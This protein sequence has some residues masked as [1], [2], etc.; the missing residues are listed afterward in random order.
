MSRLRRP[1]NGRGALHGV[2]AKVAVLVL[3]GVAVLTVA[4]GV[5]A[6]QNPLAE[7]V[8]DILKGPSAAHWFG[9][10]YLGRDL[11]SRIIA[12]TRLSV[13]TALEAVAVAVVLG[14]TPALLCLAFGK[15]FD[16]I[17]NR[18]ADAI[19]TLPVLV[20]AIA[21]IAVLGN[22][23]APVML[24]MGFL[25]APQFFR[26]TRAAALTFAGE[27]YIEAAELFGVSRA[28]TVAVHIVPKVLPTIVVTAASATA[29][30][31]LAVSSLMFLGIG[32]VP[33]APTWGG[34]LASDLSYLSQQPWAPLFPA[35]FIMLTAGSLNV[36]ADA[37]RD[38]SRPARAVVTPATAA[39]PELVLEEGRDAD[40]AAEP[41]A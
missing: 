40:I 6:P 16:W 22:R 25:T 30:A 8:G 19:M 26:V 39:A 38:R 11:F 9:T 34:V 28:R 27:Q 4:G 29:T 13:L 7:H 10:D 41:A 3:I 5:I 15:A 33:P 32:V 18:V 14:A 20:F 12:G 21:C 23:L 17:A 1:R 36:V 2:T 24:A 37:V 31:L 35:A